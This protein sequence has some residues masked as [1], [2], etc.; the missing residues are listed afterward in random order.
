[1][2]TTLLLFIIVWTIGWLTSYPRHKKWALTDR[3]AFNE[4]FPFVKPNKRVWT[5]RNFLFSIFIT[6]LFWWWFIWIWIIISYLH[7]KTV[8]GKI[9][10]WLDKKSSI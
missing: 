5:N 10:D 3:S 6:C 4:V 7:D 2:N 9:G 8:F 1:M